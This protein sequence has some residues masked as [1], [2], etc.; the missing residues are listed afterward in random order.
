MKLIPQVGSCTFPQSVL[1]SCASFG[2][3]LPK[4]RRSSALYGCKVNLQL[5]SR[6]LGLNT[7]LQQPHAA[8]CNASPAMVSGP[9]GM[10]FGLHG[11]VAAHAGAL[12]AS[13]PCGMMA[14]ISM[15]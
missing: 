8:A 15:P 14:H 9:G 12:H 4:N 11:R 1:Q 5:I 6:T 2:R 13:S 3:D 7:S 10:H